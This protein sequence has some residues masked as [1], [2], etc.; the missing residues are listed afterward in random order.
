MIEDTSNQHLQT[1]GGI[2]ANRKCFLGKRKQQM[3][4]T[5]LNSLAIGR[6]VKTNKGGQQHCPINKIW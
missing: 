2:H 3:S 6:E 1:Y 4:M 5:Y